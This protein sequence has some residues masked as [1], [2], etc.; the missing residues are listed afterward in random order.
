MNPEQSTRTTYN[1]Q[2]N[3]QYNDN[4]SL[5]AS[6]SKA[7][8]NGPIHGYIERVTGSGTVVAYSHVTYLEPGSSETTLVSTPPPPSSSI[9]DAPQFARAIESAPEVEGGEA[10]PDDHWEPLISPS[11]PLPIER[12]VLETEFR[13]LSPEG[14]AYIRYLLKRYEKQ[15]EEAQKNEQAGET[16]QR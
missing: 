14:Q 11:I 4:R 6:R 2:T 13:Q 5:H 15:Y 12:S 3:Q 10:A 1:Q 16:D 7:T 8:F 9:P